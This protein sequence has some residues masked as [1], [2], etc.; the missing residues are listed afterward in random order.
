MYTMACGFI[1]RFKGQENRP[2][3]PGLLYKLIKA[4]KL[5]KNKVSFAGVICAN[6]LSPNDVHVIFS[7]IPFDRD[8]LYL[9]TGQKHKGFIGLLEH[10]V[11]K[12]ARKSFKITLFL[13]FSAP[14]C[15]W[16]AQTPNPGGGLALK[17]WK[18]QKLLVL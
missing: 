16:N 10:L 15:G 9:V 18:R 5:L 2:K 7:D 12:M 3:R 6:H 8:Y 17:L 11:E 4:I 13:I 1:I 14:L